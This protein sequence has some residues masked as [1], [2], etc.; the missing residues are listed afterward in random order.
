MVAREALAPYDQVIVLSGD[1]PLIS[2]QTIEKLRDFHSTNHPAMTILTAQ[3][4]DPTGYGRVIRKNQRSPEVKA[5]VEEKSATSAQRKI[6]EI[7]SGFYVFDT[8]VLFAQIDELSNDNPHGEYYLT[9]MAAVFGKAKRRVMVV[10]ASDPDEILGS[11]TRAEMVEID[12]PC[13]WLSAGSLWP[14]ASRFF[15]PRPA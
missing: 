10:A 8:K 1:A 4:Q 2:S 11:N 13:A 6:R 3:L 7:N 14:K 15:T 5:I 9:D 12:Q